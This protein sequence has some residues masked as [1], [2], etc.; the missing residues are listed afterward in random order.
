MN[1]DLSDHVSCHS[2]CYRYCRVAGY[3]YCRVAGYN[4]Y[5]VAGYI[6]ILM[7][8]IHASAFASVDRWRQQ[9][10][11]GHFIVTLMAE[12]GQYKIG[13][14]HNWIIVV[15]DNQGNAIENAQIAISGGMLAHGH[16]LPS[17]PLVTRYLGQ[18]QYLIEGML[19]NMSGKWTLLFVIQTV[20]QK[21]M[22]RDRVRFDI[23]LTF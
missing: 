9:S 8:L 10:D 14:Y 21:P 13:R 4:Y 6:F 19:F 1:H 3:N 11:A 16:G 15:T 2:S 23:E 17:K 20:I 12:D 7:L 22:L 5:R 18:G